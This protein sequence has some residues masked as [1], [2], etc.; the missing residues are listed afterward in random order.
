MQTFKTSCGG[1]AAP[2]A[3][4]LPAAVWA[5]TVAGS[6]L[7]GP[8]LPSAGIYSIEKQPHNDKPTL[9]KRVHL[10]YVNLYSK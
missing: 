9:A 8:E 1:S 6:C 7:W 3:C 4:A 5:A 10:F 2:H